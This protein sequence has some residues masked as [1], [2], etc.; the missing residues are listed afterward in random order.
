MTTAFGSLGLQIRRRRAMSLPNKVVLITGASQGIGACLARAVHTRGA[1]CVL[2]A[3]SSDKLQSLCAELGERVVTVTA[4][5]TMFVSQ[6]HSF[7]PA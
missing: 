5:V 2:V 7:L 6:A 4:D 3:R 1:S